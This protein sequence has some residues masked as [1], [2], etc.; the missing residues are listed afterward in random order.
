MV[1]EQVTV[2]NETGIHARPAS[3]IVKE[4]EGFD[5]DIKIV[6]D[7][8]EVNAKSIMGIMSLGIN[9]STELIIKAEGDD[10]QVA[11]TA[12]VDLIA[13]GFGE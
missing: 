12:I 8:Q 7:D 13:D 3:M 4:A 10:A 5:A 1:E 6:K 9:Q 2:E 11:V